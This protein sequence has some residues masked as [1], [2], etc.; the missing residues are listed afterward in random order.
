MCT[1]IPQRDLS[2]SDYSWNVCAMR[3]E[4]E[5]RL[6]RPPR[7]RVVDFG[8]QWLAVKKSAIDPGTYDRYEAAL[9]DHA[10][11]CF[12]RMPFT[13]LRGLHVQSWISVELARG[14]RIATVKGWFRALRTMVQDAAED[15]ALPRD[16]TRRIRFPIADER[17]ETNALL[18][19]QLARFLDEMR[20]RYPQH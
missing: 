1:P 19:G 7:S 20:R 5:E 14:Y 9:E 13:D 12:G 17:E 10:F 2:S 6:R 18:P 15:L 3:R 8:R 11:K 4:L 16:P